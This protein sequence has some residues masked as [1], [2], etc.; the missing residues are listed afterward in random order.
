MKN[1]ISRLILKWYDHNA[2]RLP[3]RGVNDPYAVWVSEIM[4]QQTRVETVIPYYLRWME[5]YPDVQTLAADTE[6]EVLRMWEG[7]GYY[8]R[9]RHLWQAAGILVNKFN[10]QLPRDPSALESLPGV[11][12]YTAGA[13]ASM[14]FGADAPALDGNIKRILA[15]VFDIEH[16]I[17]SSAGSKRLWE[18]AA[19]LLPHGRAGD[20][21]QALMDLGALICL[22]KGPLCVDCPLAKTCLSYRQGRV[23]ERPVKTPKKI[24]PHITVTAAVIRRKDRVLIARRP[25]KGLLGG[26]WEFPGGKQQAGETLVEA[27]KREISEELAAKVKVGEELAVYQHA[28]THFRV[29]LHAYHC[30][31]VGME[32]Q[33]LEASEL[34]WVKLE[35]L[36]AYPMGNIDR[37]IANDLNCAQ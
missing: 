17:D 1:D 28:Y 20:H 29:T 12:R 18:L 11:G 24:V 10:A 30:K 23:T 6:Q 7:L 36:G 33:P 31:L 3:W 19:E 27:L 2:R 9:A 37:R 16:P 26:L 13:I 32:P 15:R 34:A 22:P 25:S 14:A 21:N 8:S 35:D 4:L 5:R